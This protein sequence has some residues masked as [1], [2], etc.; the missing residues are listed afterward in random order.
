MNASR[1]KA[2]LALVLMGGAYGAAQ[3]LTPRTFIASTRPQAKLETLFPSRFG[4]W[5]IEPGPAMLVAPDAEALISKLYSETLS[6]TYVNPRGER[7]MLSVAYGGDQS[8]A[9][10]AH[11]PEVC[12]PAQ[13][14]QLLSSQDSAYD[15]IGHRVPVRQLVTRL[16]ARTEPVSYWIVV[17]ERVAL[18]STDQK[19]AQLAYSFRGLIPDGMLVR[20]SNISTDSRASFA[21]H[22]RFV[23]EMAAAVQPT[24]LARIVGNTAA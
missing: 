10:R 4:D 17:G 13:G 8:D 20:V 24:L 5:R 3:A 14:F 23:Q 18:S 6:R 7:V 2:A 22:Q 1:R 21:L 15:V 16:G 9:T 12:Y 19:L 11:R